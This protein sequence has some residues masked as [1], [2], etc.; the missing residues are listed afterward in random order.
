MTFQGSRQ[1]SW[2]T[3]VRAGRRDEQE[4]VISAINY[5]SGSACVSAPGLKKQ[6]FATTIKVLNSCFSPQ[7]GRMTIHSLG[8]SR[9]QGAGRFLSQLLQACETPSLEGEDGG[10]LSRGC[11][12]F[13]LK[14]CFRWGR[15]PNV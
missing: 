1:V 7:G 9:K 13:F 2:G 14:S 5:I 11:S 3:G 12:F 4:R 10:L 15:V 6:S 8:G